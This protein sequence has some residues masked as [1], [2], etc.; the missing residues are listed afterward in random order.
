MEFFGGQG[1][2]WTP[3]MRF[4]H[5]FGPAVSRNS[6]SP[7]SKKNFEIISY[8]FLT[9]SKKAH[10]PPIIFPI[11]G[12]FLSIYSR[13][14]CPYNKQTKSCNYVIVSLLGIFVLNDENAFWNLRLL[15]TMEKGYVYFYCICFFFFGVK[16]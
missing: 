1:P 4:Q 2:V 15:L 6:C 13:S 8:G 12:S 9:A 11:F 3:L 14:P 16:K 7:I 10:Q 5:F